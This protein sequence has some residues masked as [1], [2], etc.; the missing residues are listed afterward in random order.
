MKKLKLT[1][2]TNQELNSN[3]MNSIKG[4]GCKGKCGSDV[5]KGAT[6]ACKAVKNNA[7]AQMRAAE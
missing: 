3:E 2:L 5:N 7:I 1:N 4:G 6:E